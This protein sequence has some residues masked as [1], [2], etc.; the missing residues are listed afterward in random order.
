MKRY[1]LVVTLSLLFTC[2]TSCAQNTDNVQVVA[3]TRPVYDLTVILCENTDISVKRLVTE[4]ISCLHDYTLQTKQ[5]RVAEAAELIVIS[6][7]GL[8]D[9]L[10]NAVD[11]NNIVADASAG[12]D[13]ISCD[14]S[15][16]DHEHALEHQHTT[17]PHIWLSPENAKIMANN[18]YN[19]LC[20]QY[21]KYEV[22]F[23]N[24]LAKLQDKLND[25]IV[26]AQ[27]QL[28]DLS[29]KEI[30]TFHDGFNYLADAFD[31]RILHAIE[32]DSGSEASAQELIHIIEIVNKQ[33][34]P[35]IFIE[36]NGSV[37]A[38]NIISAE[39][40]VKL[41]TLDMCMGTREYF[42]A[43]YHN[44]NTLKEALG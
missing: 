24:N 34:L 36:S 16:D 29:Y 7:A 22:Q 11:G 5:M 30:I 12:I 40:G 31:L 33:S 44:I 15:E 3:T 39:T 26:Y 14:S 10:S 27:Q 43:M 35:A 23:S 13:L 18:I 28:S 9:F 1:F 6:G 19:S 4:N 8:E 41:Y 17:D 38:A 32:E 2:L 21:P 25:L 20:I 37:S 42:D